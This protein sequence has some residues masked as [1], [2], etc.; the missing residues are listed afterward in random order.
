MRMIETPVSASPARIAWAIGDAPRQRG[1]QGRMDVDRSEA[2]GDRCS[3][4]REDLAVRGDDQAV[5][6]RGRQG[7]ATTSGAPIFARHQHLKSELTSRVGDGA[8]RRLPAIPR[9]IRPGDHRRR[10]RGLRARPERRHR[11]CRGATEDE[12]HTALTTPGSSASSAGSTSR[13]VPSFTLLVK[14]M[15][16]RWSSSCCTARASRPSPLTRTSLP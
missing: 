12:P 4:D 7:P 1:Q 5:R 15:P 3:A 6:D 11:E 8:R 10:P 9:S 16:S 14:R 2:A 13:S